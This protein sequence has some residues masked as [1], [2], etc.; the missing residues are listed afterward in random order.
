MVRK[1]SEVALVNGTR[2]RITRLDACG[3]VVYGDNNVAISNGFISVA[4]KANTTS[5]TAVD[6]K[7][8]NGES[9][10][11]EP[12][13]VSFS[14]YSVDISFAKVDPELFALISGQTVKHDGFGNVVGFSVDSSVSLQGQGV[15]LEVWTGSPSGDACTGGAT[16]SYGYL[17]LP[18][19]QGGYLSDHTIAE[20]G[21]SFSIS[22]MA[23]KD[24][25]A[26]GHGPY[27]VVVGADSNPST[28]IDALT[29]TEHEL[30]MLVGI[31]PPAATV[32]TRPQLDPAA[33]AVT[34]ITGT[35]GAGHTENFTVTGGG[36]S[37]GV[38]WDFGDGTWDY[39]T[40]TT[41]SHTYDAAGTYS[42]K[43]SSNGTWVTQSTT[44]A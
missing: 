20:G 18:F 22:G 11:S 21:I 12:S 38:W 43:A 2:I 16:G 7:N 34:A 41:T 19:L 33:V 23:T 26:W 10:V 35:A 40:G 1:S 36:S 42:V 25:N 14:N 15:A 31:A 32:G 8:A 5:S 4:M 9:V 44:V 13:V 28:L 30:I 29:A 39:V 24:G 6:V 37:V 27:Q 3:R 17:L